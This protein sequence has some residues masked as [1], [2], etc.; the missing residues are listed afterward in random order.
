MDSYSVFYDV[1]ENVI[2]RAKGLEKIMIIFKKSAG[3]NFNRRLIF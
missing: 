3:I 1:R 2:P